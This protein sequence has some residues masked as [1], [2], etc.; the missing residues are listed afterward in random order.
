ML[1]IKSKFKNYTVEFDNRLHLLSSLREEGDLVIIDKNI[2]EMLQKNSFW[3]FSFLPTGEGVIVL[4]ATEAAKSIE[5]IHKT[6]ALIP[7]SFKKNNKIIA[8]GGG[9][10]Q[11]V[12][13]FISS[14]VY[15]GVDWIFFPTTLLSQAD[16]CIG[17]KTSINAAAR[18]NF[19]GGFYP[20]SRIII[21]TR[22]TATLDNNN[23]L[24]GYGEIA[25]FLF[26]SSKKD[27]NF[28]KLNYSN[29][30]KR[31][32]LIK[33]CLK[34]KRRFIQKDEFDKGYRLLANY[35][36]TFGHAIE[37]ITDF[38]VPHGV[39]VAMGMQIS[40]TISYNLGVLS[41]EEYLEMS[42]ILYEIYGQFK[43][44]IDISRFIEILRLDKKNTSQGELTYIRLKKIGKSELATISYDKILDII[45]E[46]SLFLINNQDT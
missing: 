24:S 7:Q 36:H 33:R 31:K 35:G 29:P 30:I 32:D 20:P 10:V 14:T 9:V 37:S 3:E 21:N 18:K 27:F 2:Y 8:I 40:N 6:I 41:K 17:G 23:L 12:T 5:E 39:A 15:R 22:F 26:Q 19:L 43:I 13:G 38:K 16:S 25:H 44:K 28:F 34:V 45:D 42:N 11:D 4:E 1:N 46:D